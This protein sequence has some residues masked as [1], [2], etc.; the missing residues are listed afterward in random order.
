MKIQILG[1]IID[2]SRLLSARAQG[3]QGI[4]GLWLNHKE[5]VIIEIYEEEWCLSMVKIHEIIHFPEDESEGV[6]SRLSWKAE[7]KK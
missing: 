7:S 5:N 1:A 6:Q 2:F 3:Q 4:Q